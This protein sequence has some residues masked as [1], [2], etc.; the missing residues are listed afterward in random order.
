[1]NA[2]DQGSVPKIKKNIKNPLAQVIWSYL[3]HRENKVY[4]NVY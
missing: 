1:M 4:K 3:E 2:R